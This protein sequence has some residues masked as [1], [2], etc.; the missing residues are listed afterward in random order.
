MYTRLTGW[1]ET[2]WPC[3][4]HPVGQLGLLRGAHHDL[5]VDA[6]RLAASVELG[7][8]PHAHQRV[9]A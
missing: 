6:R 3:W 9:G 7:H 1:A 4:L 2:V 8:P 5:A